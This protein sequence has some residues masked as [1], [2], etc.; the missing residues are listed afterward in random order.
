MRIPAYLCARLSSPLGVDSN[1]FG[2]LR[3]TGREDVPVNASIFVAITLATLVK[4]FY[5]IA[6]FCQLK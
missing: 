1:R 3:G 6:S 5:A 4:S 2:Y